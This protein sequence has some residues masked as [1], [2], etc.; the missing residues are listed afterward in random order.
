MDIL[1][2]VVTFNLSDNDK[3]LDAE[4]YISWERVNENAKKYKQRINNEMKRVIIHGCLH[5]VGF[6]DS[7]EKE[8]K[9]MRKKEKVYL[10]KFNKDI[11]EC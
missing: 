3:D 7:T 2:D 9:E 4:V 11:I 10:N 6:D 1:T 5:L 8:I